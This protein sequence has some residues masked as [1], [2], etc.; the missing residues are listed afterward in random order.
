MH[1]SFRIGDQ[2]EESVATKIVLFDQKSLFA[3]LQS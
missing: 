3:D 2:V 1:G